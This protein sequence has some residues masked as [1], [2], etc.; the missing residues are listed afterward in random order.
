LVHQSPCFGQDGAVE[1]RRARQDDS[2]RIAEVWLRSR[3]ASVPRIP[4]PVHSDEEVQAWFEEVVVPDREVWVAEVDRT[5]VALLVLE[6]DWVDQLYVEPA[7]AG[8]GVGS[9]LIGLAKDQ[10]PKGLSL[11]TFQANVGAR[12]LYERHGFVAATTTDGDNEEGAPDVRYDWR[13]AGAP[14]G[15]EPA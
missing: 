12:R 5:I 13:P 14:P 6:G 2:L 8:K 11:W 4:P 15:P 3:A 9:R 1:L 7:W 10:R